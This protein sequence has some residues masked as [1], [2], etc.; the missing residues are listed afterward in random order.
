MVWPNRHLPILLAMLCVGDENMWGAVHS[1]IHVWGGAWYHRGIM[2]YAAAQGSLTSMLLLQYC[3]SRN[4]DIW[5]WSKRLFS[6]VLLKRQV[7]TSA[8]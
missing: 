6:I 7:A 8:E 5:Y 2:W 1:F 3:T 4:D